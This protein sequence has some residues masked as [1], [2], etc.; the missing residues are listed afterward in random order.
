VSA[1]EDAPPVADD[2]RH[3]LAVIGARLAVIERK[4]GEVTPEA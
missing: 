4:L 1:L 2:L 3:R